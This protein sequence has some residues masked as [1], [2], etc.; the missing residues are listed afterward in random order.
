MMDWIVNCKR[1]DFK[2]YMQAYLFCLIQYYLE[3][4]EGLHYGFIMLGETC[5]RQKLDVPVYLSYYRKKDNVYIVDKPILYSELKKGRN[6]DQIADYVLN[7]INELGK[8]S[9]ESEYIQQLK[10]KKVEA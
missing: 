6:K 10:E 5:L 8:M 3:E 9:F 7:R 4:L 2:L 1:L